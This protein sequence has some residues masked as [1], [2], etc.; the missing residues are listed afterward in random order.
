MREGKYIRLNGNIDGSSGFET[1]IS[2]FGRLID[3]SK[4]ASV[5]GFTGRITTND[6]TFKIIYTAKLSTLSKIDQVQN[7]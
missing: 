2:F 6:E 4:D 3:E 5:Y 1:S 7:Q